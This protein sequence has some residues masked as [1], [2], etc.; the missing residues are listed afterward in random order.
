MSTLQDQADYMALAPGVG[1]IPEKYRNRGYEKLSF[2]PGEGGI[3]SMNA[4]T[5]PATD[6]RMHAFLAGVASGADPKLLATE[7]LHGEKPTPARKG[8]KDMSPSSVENS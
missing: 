8:R 3:G 6:E 1:I 5:K 7:L 2:G 4:A